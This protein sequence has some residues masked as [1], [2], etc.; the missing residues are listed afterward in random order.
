MIKRY[1]MAAV[2]VLAYGTPV[3][4]HDAELDKLG[5]HAGSGQGNYHCHGGPLAGREFGSRLEAVEALKEPPP[6]PVPSRPADS[7]S[8]QDP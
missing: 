6:H 7:G 3:S 5:C 2:L 1:A 8:K 4:G